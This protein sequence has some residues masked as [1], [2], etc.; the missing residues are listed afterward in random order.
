[1][2][3]WNEKSK[4]L[5]EAINFSKDN[6]FE[7]LHFILHNRNADDRGNDA[8]EVIDKFY[9]KVQTLAELT[10]NSSNTY[11]EVEELAETAFNEISD[12]S[13][14]AGFREACRLWHTLNSF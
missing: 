3:G 14:D 4:T 12:Y 5:D 6:I 10:E 13:Y 9:E 8:N 2:I 7:Y 11:M 1:M